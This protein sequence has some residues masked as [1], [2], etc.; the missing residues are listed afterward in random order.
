MICWMGDKTNEI[1][2]RHGMGVIGFDL[3]REARFAH[4]IVS[5]NGTEMGI[6][7]GNV[8][9]LTPKEIERRFAAA[10]LQ[11]AMRAAEDGDDEGYEVLD[12]L[13]ES[14]NGKE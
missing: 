5:M 9:G 7:L 3:E 4:C 1:I 2:D 13:L 8:E 10:M 11:F 12:E 6:N 14:L